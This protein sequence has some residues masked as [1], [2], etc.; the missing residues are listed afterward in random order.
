[1]AGMIKY[2]SI[3]LLLSASVATQAQS[4][5]VNYHPCFLMDSVDKH[6]SFIGQSAGRIFIDS[7]DCREALLDSIAAGY[8]RTKDAKYLNTLAS[9]RQNPYAKAD[10]LYTDVIKKLVESDFMDFVD[11]LYLAKGGLL[12]LQNELIATMN[13]IIDGRPFKQK[14]IGLL[15]VEIERAKDS[16]DKYRVLYLEKLKLKINEEKYH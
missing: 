11:K 7:F 5:K 1:M 8:E 10:E 16:N 2:L 3:L 6:L 14:Y 13:T 9:I 4:K 12:P 15:N